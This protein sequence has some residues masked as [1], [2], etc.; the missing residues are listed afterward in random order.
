MLKPNLKPSCEG[1]AG[2]GA[3]SSVAAGVS[4]GAGAGSATGAC[5]LHDANPKI[6]HATKTN[7]NIFFTFITLISSLT[8]NLILLINSISEKNL[9]I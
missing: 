9:T 6:R 3:L 4:T 7:A 1:A 5:L 2:A 8:I